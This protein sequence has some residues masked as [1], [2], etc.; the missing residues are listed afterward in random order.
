MLPTA[1]RF[2]VRS[3]RAFAFLLRAARYG[4]QDGL[5]TTLRSLGVGELSAP[6]AGIQLPSATVG[7]RSRSPHETTGADS[8]APA[9]A[10]A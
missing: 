6:L 2:S 7:G 9:S 10:P 5:S 8:S 3:A 4:G 1:I